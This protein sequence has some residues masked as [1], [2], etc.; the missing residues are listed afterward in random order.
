MK[1]LIQEYVFNKTNKTITFAEVFT[2]EQILLITN[3]TDNIVIYNFADSSLGGSLVGNVLTLAYDTSSMSD[4]DSIQIFV[5]I[6]DPN[7]D[8]ADLLKL[9]TRMAKM[10][11]PLMTVDVNNR[12]RVAVEAIPN[13][14]TTTTLSATGGAN[15]TGLGYPATCNTVGGNPYSLTASQPAQLIAS[16]VDQRWELMENSHISYGSLRSKLTFS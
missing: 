12:Q 10:L 15:V 9:I 6:P 11:E 14:T 2:L 8:N 1:K 13:V 3:V 5:D 7:S 16:V 4:T